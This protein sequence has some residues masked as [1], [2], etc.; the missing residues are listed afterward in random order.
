MKA[1]SDFTQGRILFPLIKFT[2]PLMLAIFLQTMYGAIDLLVVGRFGTAAD[3]SAISTGSYIMMAITFIIADTAMGLTILLGRKIGARETE[4]A[5]NV[6]GSGIL[7][8]TVISLIITVVMLLSAPLLSRAMMI[9]GE[10]FASCNNYIRICSSG[11]LFIVGYNLIG[12]IFRGLGN[13][14]LPLIVVAIAC[15]F[16]IVGDLIFVAVFGMG[17]E[18]AALATVISQGLSVIISFFIVK[19]MKKPF[20]FGIHSLRWNRL[21]NNTVLRLGFPLAIQEIMVNVSYLVIA[22]IVNTFGVIPS[23]GVGIADKLVGFIFIVPVSFMQAMAAFVAQNH[24]ARK[25]ER[26]EK[27]LVYGIECSILLGLMIGYTTFFHGDHFLRLFSPDHQIIAVGFEYLRAFSL[28][29]LIIAVLFSFLGYFNGMG[30]TNFVMW[31][32][33]IG[34]ICI[35]IPLAFLINALIPGNIFMLTLSI[36]AASLFQIIL[37]IFYMKRLKR[38][39]AQQ[40]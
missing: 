35:R 31:Q 26:A 12:A 2:L 40:S 11:A 16:N 9:P 17:A 7:L 33:I 19:K 27:A 32:G 39:Q 30:K 4:E 22:A 28:E 23:A 14:R 36:P 24:G 3:V 37:C 34:S 21:Y 38:K 25:P 1:V 18:G 15:F 5:G 29:C 20:S 10:A 8:F 6:I 13:S